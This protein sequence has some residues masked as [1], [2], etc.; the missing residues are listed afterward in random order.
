[1]ALLRCK[2]ARKCEWVDRIF[3]EPSASVIGS[4]G[5]SYYDLVKTVLSIYFNKWANR[6]L[7]RT[8]NLLRV[9]LVAESGYELS[10]YPD[11][12]LKH[13]LFSLSHAAPSQLKGLVKRLLQRLGLENKTCDWVRIWRLSLNLDL[14]LIFKTEHIVS[15]SPHLHGTKCIFH[16]I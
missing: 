4:W 1:M 12:M 11:A 7:E 10:S 9:M 8:G 15:Q 14:W 2:A 3:G 16:Q 6:S 13:M 5:N